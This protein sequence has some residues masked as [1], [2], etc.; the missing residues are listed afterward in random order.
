M[1]MPEETHP[2]VIALASQI[3]V[4]DGVQIDQLLLDELRAGLLSLAGSEEL[5]KACQD[6]FAFAFVLSREEAHARTAKLIIEVLNDEELITAMQAL[7]PPP[8]SADEAVTSHA[9]QFA[10]FKDENKKIAPKVGA[11]APK[12]SVKIDTFK[13]PRRI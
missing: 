1:K 9:D 11:R 8:L 2:I 10:H 13:V 4:E 3:F 12:G 6:I 7:A 5:R